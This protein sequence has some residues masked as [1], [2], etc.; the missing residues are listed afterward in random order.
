MYI[1]VYICII[2]MMYTCS[3]LSMYEMQRVNNHH[4][5]IHLD[6]HTY[7]SIYKGGH[8]YTCVCINT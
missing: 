6:I 3:Y 7:V 2:Y 4:I 8:V 1:F 5:Y